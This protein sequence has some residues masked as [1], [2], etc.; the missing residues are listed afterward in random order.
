MLQVS[1][2]WACHKLQAAK[3]AELEAMKSKGKPKAKNASTQVRCC[4]CCDVLFVNLASMLYNA[5]AENVARV[6]SG[7]CT[8]SSQYHC[9]LTSHVRLG[10]HVALTAARY[11]TLYNALPDNES[12][13]IACRL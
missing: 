1:L 12:A 2:S 7:L 5:R 3:A 10:M 13:G 6:P 11:R 8:G 4:G 9:G